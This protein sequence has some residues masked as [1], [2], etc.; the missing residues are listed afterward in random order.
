MIQ[1]KVIIEKFGQ[2]GEKTG[3]TYFAIPAAIA[4]KLNKGIKTSYR[5]KGFLD[6]IPINGVAILPMG[7]GEFIM[8]LNADLRKKIGKKKNDELLVKLSVDKTGY[9][10]NDDM[11][12]C[13]Q[14]EKEAFDRFTAMPRSHQHYYSKWVDSAKTETTKAKRI[15]KVIQS[16]ILKQTFAEML[17]S[18]RR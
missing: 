7:E 13:L 3:W 5:V 8:P 9:Q 11:M 18:D 15:A 17:K 4:N 2:Q 10:L 16:M 12:A 6:E 1:F 14:D